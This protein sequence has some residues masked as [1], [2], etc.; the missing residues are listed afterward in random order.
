MR[1]LPTFLSATLL[2]A[3]GQLGATPL[4]RA[5]RVKD[6]RQARATDIKKDMTAN[7]VLNLAGKPQRIGRQILFRR[8]LEQ[9]VFDD[10]GIRVE[11]TCLPGEEPR[12]QSV[13]RNPPAD[14]R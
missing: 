9:W 8:H 11:F 10:L 14:F 12:V 4:D 1:F 3:V 13:L 7:E 6:D 2:V 5:A